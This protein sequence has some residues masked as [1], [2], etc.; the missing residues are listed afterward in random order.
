MIRRKNPVS[1]GMLSYNIGQREL[2][3]HNF[4]W[5]LMYSWCPE[6][7]MWT[8]AFSECPKL[9]RSRKFVNLPLLSSKTILSAAG[10]RNGLFAASAWKLGASLV[11]FCFFTSYNVKVLDP[12]DYSGAHRRVVLASGFEK[13][14]KRL[15]CSAF[16]LS[17][18]TLDFFLN[19]SL[20]I[21]IL[22][23]NGEEMRSLFST[24]SQ[25]EKIDQINI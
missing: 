3:E 16:E 6:K 9:D 7:N 1:D 18:Y 23:S 4:W 22:I 10:G 21:S 5:S 13:S 24:K 2:I 12:S 14:S 25:C 17:G 19:S 20:E 11:Q 15:S 8:S